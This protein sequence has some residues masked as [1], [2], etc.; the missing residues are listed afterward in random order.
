MPQDLRYALRMLLRSPGFTLVAV[1][2]LA[3]GIGANTAVFTLVNALLLK[4][5]PGS[6]QGE[7]VG[8]Y[9]RSAEQG[10][11]RALSYPNFRDLRLGADVFSGVF[12]M[13]FAMVGLTEGTETRRI[14]A[15]LV[16]SDFFLTMG[17]PLAA[18]RAF[19]PEE[20]RPG[21]NVP[22]AVASHEHWRKTGFDPHLVG[23]TLRINGRPFTV[24]GIAARGFT[25]TMALFGPELWVPLGVYESL[26]GEGTISGSSAR[27]DDRSNHR[28][29][30]A[31]RL[32]PG[33][34]AEAA[35]PRLEAL[36][37][38]L[39]AAYPA[40][41]D[42]HTLVA[43]PLGRLGVSSS[44]QNNTEVTTTSAF[45]LGMSGIVLLVACLNLANMLLARGTARRKEIAIRLAV[46]AGRVRIVRQL[47]IEGFAL[48]AAGSMGGLVL[49]FWATRVMA[50][51]L[52][53]MLPLAVSLDPAPD[54]RVLGATLGFAGLAT[55]LASLGPAWK[56]SR[57]DVVPDLKEQVAETTGRR[58]WRALLSARHTLVVGQV[59]LSLVLLTAGGMFVH[60]TI[61]A[62]R[63]D[64]GFSMERG[65]LVAVDPG[66]GGY[67]EPRTRNA[68]RRVLSS[69]RSLPGVEAASYASLVAFG[70][71]TEM[72]VFER[73]GRAPGDEDGRAN[74]HHYIVSADYFRT[75]G[76]PVLRGREFTAAEEEAAS[77]RRVAIVD[78]TLARRFWP[79]GEPLGQTIRL[80]REEGAVSGQGS[81]APPAADDYEVIGV[82]GNTRHD[83]LEHAPS[84][85]VYVPMGTHYRS[86]M[87]LHVRVAQGGPEVAEAMLGTIAREVRQIDAGVP[88][89]SQ[90]TLAQHRGSSLVLW[91]MGAGARVFTAFGVLALLLAAVGLY[92][93]KSY[94]VA[95][96]TREI[97]IRMALGA[98]S[99]DVL[100]MVLRE[101]LGVTA[102]G[103]AIGAVLSVGVGTVLS[104][105]L[106]RVDAI[107]PVTF[108]LAP[109]VL[110][111]AALVACWLPARRAT[112]V[113][114]VHALRGE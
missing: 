90:R 18:G 57:P 69:V 93:V 106:Y 72:R 17:S 55:V 29:V 32:Q 94:M 61:N 103:V 20:E 26:K 65:L 83:L 77:P 104:S 37:A 111:T 88:I 12:A 75:L 76:I 28:L 53:G 47:L 43:R 34:G 108:T 71:I 63:S 35:A 109:L 50:V 95:R 36:A 92:G 113:V 54:I 79:A 107:D 4:P 48:A 11:W 1:L 45:L 89:L 41:N 97:G 100:W 62:A 80:V 112:R 52:E 84:P 70:D 7:L 85:H 105:W 78:E 24:V 21:S 10:Q 3:L 15:A 13:D 8:V 59:A 74:A 66:L 42:H 40:D 31:G 87:N 102:A 51:S 60:G 68:L 27:L 46:G 99:R 56:L 67:D 39:A 86:G 98:Q 2:V 9:G 101:G 91:M 19:R 110:L 5:L 58:G 49:A 22:V 16:S 44:P 73:F 96:R 81:L 82:V 6:A 25:G 38:Q 114:P 14:F 30:V 64:P 33:L 23:S